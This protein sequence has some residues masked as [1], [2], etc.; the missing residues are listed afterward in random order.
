MG[1]LWIGSEMNYLSFACV[2][3]CL[4]LRHG[5]A[6]LL[7]MN[8]GIVLASILNF[9]VENEVL[10]HTHVCPYSFSFL[11]VNVV[12]GAAT[13]QLNPSEV[14]Q[15]HSASPSRRLAAERTQH[16]DDSFRIQDDVCGNIQI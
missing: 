4:T 10:L 3:W 15:E 12:P 2:W 16:L 7:G 13:A 14:E 5:G 8:C 6:L 11:S 9:V 1:N